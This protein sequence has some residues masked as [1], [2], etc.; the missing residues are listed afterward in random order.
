MQLRQT[1]MVLIHIILGKF[2]HQ[3]RCG[4]TLY[5]FFDNGPENSN[6]TRQV[7]HRIVDQLNSHRI[8]GDKMLGCIHRFVKTRKMADTHELFCG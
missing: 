7:D 2:N 5:R 3:Q 6:G 4:V 8:K 1:A